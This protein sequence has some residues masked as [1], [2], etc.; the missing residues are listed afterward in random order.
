MR[1]NCGHS[2]CGSV[3]AAYDAADQNLREINRLCRDVILVDIKGTRPSDDDLHEAFR[4]R[5]EQMKAHFGLSVVPLPELDV[6]MF[7]DL[8]ITRTAPFEERTAGA[9]KVVTGCK[10]PPF[11][12]P[13]W[14][15]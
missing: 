12:S 4:K 8:A 2:S 13:F 5:S 10:T 9:D 11:C 3:N 6:R 1:A 15:T 14:T 7:V